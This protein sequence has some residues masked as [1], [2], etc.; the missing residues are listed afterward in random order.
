MTSLRFEQWVPFA[1][2][3]VFLFFADPRNLPR[4]M[5][6]NT[7]TR[8]VEIRSAPPSDETESLSRP[9]TEVVTS[10]RPI[11]FLPIRTQWIALITEFEPNQHFADVQKTG[12]FKSWHHR[13]EFSAQMHDGF[14]GTI[15]R[16]VI[17]YDVGF[18]F[19]GRLADALFVRRT[20]DAMSRFCY[21]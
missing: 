20:F 18:G 9:G 13:H 19:V 11:P 8:I 10:F 3:R 6:P 4:I 12:P 1:P 14:N 5:P 2:Q 7:A 21:P 15:V 16:D 17:N